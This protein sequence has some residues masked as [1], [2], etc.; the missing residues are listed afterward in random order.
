ME[1]NQILSLNVATIFTKHNLVSKY[2]LLHISHV[3]ELMKR[4]PIQ[5]SLLQQYE[6]Q[7]QLTDCIVPIMESKITKHSKKKILTTSDMKTLLTQ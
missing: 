1:W 7:W 3:N 4:R 6:N 5:S 2:I